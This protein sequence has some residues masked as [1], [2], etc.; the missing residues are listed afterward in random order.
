LR[1]L[2]KRHCIAREARFAYASEFAPLL[3]YTLEIRSIPWID[4]RTFSQID[5]CGVPAS[6]AISSCFVGLSPDISGYQMKI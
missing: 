5:C 6:S 2:L 1:P 3:L 4:I